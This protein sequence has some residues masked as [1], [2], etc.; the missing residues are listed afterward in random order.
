MSKTKFVSVDDTQKEKK[1]TIFTHFLDGEEGWVTANSTPH[2]FNKVLY[3]GKD[4]HHGD[5]FC[6]YD[7]FYLLIYKGTKGDEFNQ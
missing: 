2:T 1:E 5:M 3:L 7:D 6:G 4:Q